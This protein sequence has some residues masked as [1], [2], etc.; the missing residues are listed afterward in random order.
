M[1]TGCVYIQTVVL[2]GCVCVQTVVLTGC[3]YVQTV[4]FKKP[5]GRKTT[6]LTI[7][8]DED[9]AEKIPSAQDSSKT[10]DSAGTG[11]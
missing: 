2:T 7:S 9:S 5:Q 4:A 11:E 8:D 6:Q 3:M 10:C 1:L